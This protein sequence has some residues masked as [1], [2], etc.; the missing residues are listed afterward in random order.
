MSIFVLAYPDPLVYLCI[1]RALFNI[2]KRKHIIIYVTMTTRYIKNA[3]PK[4][5]LLFHFSIFFFFFVLNCYYLYQFSLFF[6]FVTENHQLN[7]KPM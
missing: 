1:P 7:V 4:C 2:E 5:C 6:F 3:N